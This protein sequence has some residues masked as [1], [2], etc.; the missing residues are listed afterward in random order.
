MQVIPV[1]L[2]VFYCLRVLWWRR[3]ILQL[4][5]NKL[6]QTQI[7]VSELPTTAKE[8]VSPCEGWFLK[9]AVTI[10]NSSTLLS[11]YSMLQSMTSEQSGWVADS[12]LWALWFDFFR[13][14]DAIDLDSL[15]F[16]QSTAGPAVWAQGLNDTHS[17]ES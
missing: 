14:L 7:D 13:G 8:S 1:C 15:V 3:C 12:W 5:K 4:K 6:V 16:C 11:E 17:T 9:Y 10:L 2:F